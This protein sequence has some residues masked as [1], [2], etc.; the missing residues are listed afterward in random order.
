MI[1]GPAGGGMLFGMTATDLNKLPASE[2]SDLIES[3]T[4]T[5]V[6][7]AVVI[8]KPNPDMIL[9]IAYDT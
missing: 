9:L 7:T 2:I 5:P 6:K 8:K 3:K 4:F 1:L